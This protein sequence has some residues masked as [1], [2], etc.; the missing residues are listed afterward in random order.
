MVQRHDDPRGEPNV[1]GQAKRY[2]GKPT[3]EGCTFRCGIGHAGR[4][5]ADLWSVRYSLWLPQ[6]PQDAT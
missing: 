4:D 3:G 2:A 1:L 6:W 5:S